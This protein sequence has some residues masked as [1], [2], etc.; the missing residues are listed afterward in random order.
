MEAK[1]F[2]EIEK[3]MDVKTIKDYEKEVRKKI[4]NELETLRKEND[5]LSRVLMASECEMWKKIRNEEY[6]WLQ[7]NSDK[8]KKLYRFIDIYSNFIDLV[9]SVKELNTKVDRAKQLKE[10]PVDTE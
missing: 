9:D 7:L 5:D 1:F 8:K 3:N 10:T 6:S 2:S 4:Y